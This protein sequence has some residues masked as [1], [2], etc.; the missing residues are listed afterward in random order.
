M[1]ISLFLVQNVG[2][3]NVLTNGT[4]TLYR[5]M[6]GVN[7]LQAIW[8]SSMIFENPD[9]NVQAAFQEVPVTVINFGQETYVGLNTGVIKK[10][11][12][13]T[14]IRRFPELKSFAKNGELDLYNMMNWMNRGG[15]AIN[16][17][18]EFEGK[19]FDASAFGLYC[20]DK[21]I[22]D[23]SISHAGVYNNKLG[24]VR[25]GIRHKLNKS[26]LDS[27]DLS[28][29]GLSNLYDAFTNEIIAEDIAPFDGS[30][31]ARGKFVIA[32][33]KC[34]MFH[35]DF[36]NELTTIKS[37]PD[38]KILKEI[39]DDPIPSNFAVYDNS[40]FYP[41]SNHVYSVYGDLNTIVERELGYILDISNGL[42]YLSVYDHIN[43][44]SRIVD[45]QKPSGILVE[46]E[47]KVNFLTNQ[48][49]R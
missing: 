16:S 11:I 14:E 33:G 39:K 35:G 25:N 37:F 24:I 20:G 9:E 36:G 40:V 48:N 3:K 34:Y 18:V 42:L 22:I 2:A 31:G 13:G 30:G 10:V 32:N 1:G 47:G 44:V 27:Q 46:L 4:S 5:F 38:G 29:G 21:K 26:I 41:A 6:P 28:K 15:V 8:K 49:R 12:E 17:L 45:S 23:E 19:L 7:E 43:N